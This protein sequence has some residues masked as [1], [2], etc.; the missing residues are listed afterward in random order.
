MATSLPGKSMA[1]AKRIPSLRFVLSAA[2][3]FH[4]ICQ[5]A[6]P[7]EE[8]MPPGGPARRVPPDPG[9]AAGGRLPAHLALLSNRS[10]SEAAGAGLALVG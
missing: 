7:R 5:P 10:H 1:P 6:S 2:S 9:E 4:D 8:R 3:L